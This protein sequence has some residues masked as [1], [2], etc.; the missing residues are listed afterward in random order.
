MKTL[1]ATATLT[2]LF[3]SAGA[4]A[5]GSNGHAPRPM[6]AQ[7]ANVTVINKNMAWPIAGRISVEACKLS[8][9]VDI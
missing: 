7:T 4:F 6:L 5:G 8:R 3:L 9:C 1:T 2:A